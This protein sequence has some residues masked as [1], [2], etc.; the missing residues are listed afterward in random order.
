MQWL[1]EHRPAQDRSRQIFLLTDGEIS[2]VDQVLD[3]CR[4]MAA[5]S[6]IFSFGLGQSPSRSLV[7]GL[8]RATN[9]RF[10][11]VPPGSNV[12]L[13]VGQQLQKALQVSVTNL[14]I[15]WNLGTPAISVPEKI[16]PI[17]ANDR[18]ILYAL[19]NDSTATF[20][21]DA[22]VELYTD[23][24]RFGPVNVNRVPHV[25]EN[26]V[27]ARLAA[28]A[29]ILQLQHSKLPSQNNPESLQTRF[30]TPTQPTTVA[31]QKAAMKQQIVQLSLK[32]Q[33]LSP[34]TAFVGVERREKGDN[35][36][37]VL[38]EVP[39]KISS[40]DQ[41]LLSQSPPF[42]NF[43]AAAPQAMSH[44]YCSPTNFTSQCF[45]MMSEAACYA[46]IMC[47][48][49][50]Q[51]FGSSFE[52]AIA[53]GARCPDDLFPTAEYHHQTQS[54]TG[55]KEDVW[56]TG[57][58]NIV[59]YLIKKQKFDG[60]WELDDSHLQQLAGKSLAA[61]S[62]TSNAE[63]LLSAIVIVALE[64][65]FASLSTLWFGVVQKARQR[66]LDLLGSDQKQLDALL[67]NIREQF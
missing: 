6:R 26:G 60:R 30:Q 59:R 38:R 50:C 20:N 56:P 10:V 46:D 7:K 62:S 63:L 36:G 55:G 16:P 65:R 32:H 42:M 43:Y 39:I 2:N 58:E 61:F 45:D 31:E 35:A 14:Q 24:H 34:H 53:P 19:A 12:D 11:F 37:M 41:H 8:A 48:H 29:L 67:E 3:L 40:D 23:K 33:I 5:S 66:L 15:T 9:G 49:D 22:T 27:I 21:P 44:A 52:F 28:K 57:D 4:S 54:I 25:T 64:T 18:L 13:Y 47:D 17:Y 51:E 1:E